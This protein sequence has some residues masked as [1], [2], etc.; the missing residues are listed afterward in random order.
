MSERLE[1]VM[2]IQVVDLFRTPNAYEFLA[3]RLGY[4]HGQR[5]VK[6]KL[7]VLRRLLSEGRLVQAVFNIH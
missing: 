2:D 5:F 4:I 1:R 3:E 6:I 7:P